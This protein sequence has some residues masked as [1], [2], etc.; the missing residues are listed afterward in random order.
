MAYGDHICVDRGWYTHDGIDLGDETV[1]HR[2]APNG[3]KR[4]SLIRQ[5]TLDVFAK[6]AP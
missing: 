1:I 4:D 3:A 2:H 5:T 6:A